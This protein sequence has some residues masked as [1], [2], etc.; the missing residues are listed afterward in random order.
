MKENRSIWEIEDR[1]ELI[2]TLL[3][4]LLGIVDREIS[5]EHVKCELFVLLKALDAY[6]SSERFKYNEVLIRIEVM[7]NER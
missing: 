7:R 2:E 5:V 6:K 3:I 4:L 1:K